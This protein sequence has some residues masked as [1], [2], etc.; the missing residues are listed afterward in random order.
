MFISALQQN[1]S[2]IYVGVYICIYICPLFFRF[3]S[4]YRSLQS[5][6]IE[7]PVL[8]SRSFILHIVLY[9]CQYICQSQSHNLSLPLLFPP[10]TIRSFSTSV[11]LFLLC[12]YVHLYHFLDSTYKQ[13]HMIFVFLC[14]TYFT[15][16]DVETWPAKPVLQDCH[17]GWDL[18]SSI[19]QSLAGPPHHHV[20]HCN[21]LQWPL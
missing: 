19:F 14:P 8:Y 3:F 11:T 4:P 10:G 20:R 17:L 16:C 18:H 9:I 7:F 6:W 1:E 21:A 5:I 2:Y 13:Y 15:Q 12:K